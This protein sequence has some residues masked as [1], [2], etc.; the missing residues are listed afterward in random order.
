MSLFKR[1]CKLLKGFWK[2]V[3]INLGTEGLPW[4]SKAYLNYLKYLRAYLKVT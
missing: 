4:I 3:Y 1:L 2:V